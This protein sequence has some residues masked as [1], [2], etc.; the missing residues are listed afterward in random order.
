MPAAYREHYALVRQVASKE[1][2]LEWQVPEGWNRLCEF[3][4][5]KRPDGGFP[6]INDRE[7]IVS[8]HVRIRNSGLF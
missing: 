4:G 8:N 6:R 3:L 2:L 5:V 7:E 1:R